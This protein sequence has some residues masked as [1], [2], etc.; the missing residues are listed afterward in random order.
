MKRNLSD[1]A[2]LSIFFVWIRKIRTALTVGDGEVCAGHFQRQ[3]DPC[4]NELF[5]GRSG[6]LS[7]QITRSGNQEVVVSVTAPEVAVGLKVAQSSNQVFAVEIGAVPYQIVPREPRAVRNEIAWSHP[8]ARYRVVQL[9]FGQILAHRFVPVQL[10]LII[11]N[12]HRQ[13]GEGFAGGSDGKKS[14]WSDRQFMFYIPHS[15]T[16]RAEHFFV[17]HNR[18]GHARQLRLLHF[19]GHEWLQA[20]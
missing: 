5:P 1:G 12:S 13:G 10:A 11:E 9:K 18:Y 19:R 17:L 2:A 8:L 16:F 4:S 3:Q 20:A 7:D 14:L 15:K 6:N